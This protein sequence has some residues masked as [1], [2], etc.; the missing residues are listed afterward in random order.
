[1]GVGCW[2]GQ[3]EQQ[4]LTEEIMK[5]FLEQEAMLEDHSGAEAAMDPEE[6][7][8]R[9]RVRATRDAAEDDAGYERERLEEV[10]TAVFRRRQEERR[11]KAA[12][13]G[14]ATSSPSG[15]KRLLG[16]ATISLGV[17]LRARWVTL[18]ARWVTLRARW[19]TDAKISLGDTQR[20]RWVTLRARWKTR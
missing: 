18:R 9:Q 15:A 12:A 2:A 5:Q 14:A 3:T 4:A 10:K 20:A 6:R 19:V 11:G 7:E 13:V 1:L 8:F 16:D 17:T